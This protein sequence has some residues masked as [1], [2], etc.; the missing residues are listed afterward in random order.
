VIE[1]Y[2]T[3]ISAAWAVVSKLRLAVVPIDDN[4]WWAGSMNDHGGDDPLTSDTYV[5]QYM[6]DGMHGK[7]ADTAPHAICLAALKVVE[8]K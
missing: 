2:S 1:H 3:D 5:E 7:I 6:G 8:G 4:K